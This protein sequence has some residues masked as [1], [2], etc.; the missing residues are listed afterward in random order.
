MQIQ[1]RLTSA[2][3]LVSTRTATDM[4][5]KGL[6]PETAESARQAILDL[7]PD[8]VPHLNQLDEQV[9]MR[10]I[11]ELHRAGVLDDVE[12]AD[13]TSLVARMAGRTA[14]R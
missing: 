7:R 10:A 2:V 3:L 4:V 13:K 11:L 8:E 1:R 6:R 9:L 14:D 12:M 5:I